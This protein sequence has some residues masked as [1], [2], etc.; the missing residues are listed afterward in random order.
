[1]S[2]IL[3]RERRGLSRHTVLMLSI[4]LVVV[5][6]LATHP[7]RY[8]G[9]LVNICGVSFQG[10]IFD[11]FPCHVKIKFLI[12]IP[13]K[14]DINPTPSDSTV[15]SCV[16]PWTVVI[17][18]FPGGGGLTTNHLAHPWGSTTSRHVDSSK[19]PWQPHGVLCPGTKSIPCVQPSLTFALGP[20]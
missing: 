15:R 19:Q 1:M 13:I 18:T 6:Q 16:L 20:V 4:H 14:E 9:Y 7:I 8:Q 2:A 3:L 17:I 5:K 10:C 11:H 12:N